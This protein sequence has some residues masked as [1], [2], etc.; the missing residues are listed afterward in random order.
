MAIILGVL[1]SIVFRY[2]GQTS[3]SFP[4]NTKVLN[5]LIVLALT[6]AIV[7]VSP[8]SIPSFENTSSATLNLSH[9]YSIFFLLTSEFWSVNKYLFIIYTM[10]LHLCNFFTI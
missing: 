8:L 2:I 9:S 1:I 10:P 7:Q 6:F 4:S 5:F 3:D